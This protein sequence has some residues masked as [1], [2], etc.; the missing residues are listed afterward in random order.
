MIEKRIA[1]TYPSVGFEPT[2][3]ALFSVGSKP[4]DGYTALVPHSE[5]KALPR[6]ILP[7]ACTMPFKSLLKPSAAIRASKVRCIR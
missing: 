4:T 2:D 6:Y 1:T 3:G 7:L 5:N